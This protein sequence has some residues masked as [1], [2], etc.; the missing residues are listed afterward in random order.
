MIV[1]AVARARPDQ[2]RGFRVPTAGVGVHVAGGAEVVP[3]RAVRIRGDMRLHVSAAARGVAVDAVGAR[4]RTGA[5]VLSL[6][7]GRD[8]RQ[9]SSKN[10]APSSA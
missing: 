5:R 1:I 8:E 9:C 6:R 3:L 4:V 10:R 7:G 2:Y